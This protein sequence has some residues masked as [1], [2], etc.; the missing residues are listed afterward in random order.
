MQERKNERR[1]NLGA[2]ARQGNGIVLLV[3]AIVSNRKSETKRNQD[4]DNEN[5]KFNFVPCTSS[6]RFRI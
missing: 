4:V 2:F 3:S 1:S 5:G 6:A